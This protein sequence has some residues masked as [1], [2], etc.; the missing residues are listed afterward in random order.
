MTRKR[1][2]LLILTVA[3]LPFAMT[4]AQQ[5]ENAEKVKVIIS[6]DQGTRV[7]VDTTFSGLIDQGDSV[8]LKNGRMIFIGKSPGNER[9]ISLPDGKS[10]FIASGKSKDGEEKVREI[11]VIKSDTI[12]KSGDIKTGESKIYVFSS[13]DE[14]EP[15]EHYEIISHSL[16]DRKESGNKYI[17][18]NDD[19]GLV[20]NR[21][22]NFSISND[23]LE[24]A[25]DMETPKYVIAKN[26]IVVS[27]EGKDEARIKELLEEINKK[28]DTY[29][30]EPSK[31]ISGNK[32]GAGKNKK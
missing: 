27:V 10:I 28:L 2:S 17:Y 32:K 5:K 7:I 19:D 9:V 1:I 12:N 24:S 26:G 8:A 31:E 4:S 25:D 29:K 23:T 22:S 16:N 13:S 15:A 30:S 14:N 21:G 3:L 6:D 11:T 20:W 18:I